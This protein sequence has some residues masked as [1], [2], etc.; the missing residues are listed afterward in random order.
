VNRGTTFRQQSE[1]WID[2][3]RTRQRKP[4]KPATIQNWRS[5]LAKWVNPNL[6]DVPLAD[7]NNLVLKGFVSKLVD[8]C[9]SSNSIRLQVQTVKMVVASAIDANGEPM[10]PR[11]WNSN[12]IDLPEIRGSMQQ[13]ANTVYFKSTTISGW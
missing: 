2:H 5:C 10:Y 4:V 7:V 3:M 13:R 9:L 8:A 6:G 11:K 1:W 12:F